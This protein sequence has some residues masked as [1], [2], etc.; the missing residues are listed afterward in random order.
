MKNL[1]R[2][3]L[4]ALAIA[5]HLPMNANDMDAIE[6][7]YGVNH[8]DVMNLVAEMCAAKS[9]ADMDMKFVQL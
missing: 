9:V 7:E 6:R 1:E 4:A 2:M 3:T 5:M 8:H